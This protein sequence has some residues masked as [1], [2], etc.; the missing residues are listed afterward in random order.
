MVEDKDL[1]SIQQARHLVERSCQAGEKLKDFTQEQVD[2]IVAAMASAAEKNAQRLA[3]MAHEETGYGKVADK[4]VKNLFCAVDV[5]NYVK[6][7]KTCGVVSENKPK[8]ITEIA[9]PA[10]VIA[11]IIPSTNPTSTAI[12][13]ILCSIKGR[14]T[15][16]LSPHPK[17][18]RCTVETAR[19]MYEAA[20]QSGAPED[21]ITWMDVVTL[22]G[23]SELM[24]HPG[25]NLILATGGPGLVRAAYSSGKPAFGV[26]PGNVPAF[27]ERTADVPKAVRDIVAGKTF[28]NGTLCSSEQS[29]VCDLPIE[30]QVIEEL[31]KNGAHFLSEEETEKLGRLVQLPNKA[32][33]PA[34]VGKSPQTI[35]AMAGFSVPEHIVCLL[36]RPKGVGREHPLS[37]E[38]LSPIL[39]F[40]VED[41]WEAGCRRC[42]EILNFYGLGHTMSIHSRDPRVILEFGLHKPA[43]RIC[44][45][46][47]A[48]H[49]SVGL[50]TGVPPSMT[51]GCGTPGGNITSDNITPLHLI[52]IKRLAYEIRPLNSIPYLS[53]GK[54]VPGGV[55]EC[56]SCSDKAPL[57]V[58]S[59]IVRQV[60]RSVVED[61]LNQKK[62]PFPAPVTKSGGVPPVAER[63]E[64][65]DGP[66]TPAV[67]TP[68]AFV[69]ED[70]V[71][72]AVAKKEKIV[73]G[74]RT[75]VTPA[76][77]DLGEAK[78]V[79]LQSDLPPV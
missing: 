49:G 9:V 41:G 38:K 74:A 22:E 5:H 62:T 65:G 75:I 13:K 29:I 43:Y 51:L 19:L 54:R 66:Q 70:D 35:A 10:G 48:T 7:L 23:T 47:P 57:K 76:A 21:C 73:I 32:L 45:N 2:S 53:A 25:T 60:I 42:I 78:G 79:F 11:A 37:M 28:D 16:V 33:N 59:E 58:D 56:S 15:I 26:G 64:K 44:V 61:Y 50:T 46:T 77:R 18:V 8:G 30:N 27:I 72:R 6:D 55:P 36:G 39:G 24:K 17:A 34:I 71:R 12:F 52:N 31:R 1:I 69:C 67:G 4:T 63:A 14:N 40:F 20:L 68:V 3:Q